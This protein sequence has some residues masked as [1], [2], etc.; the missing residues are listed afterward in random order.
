[1]DADIWYKNS[2]F[3]CHF[4]Y[5][6]SWQFKDFIKCISV[7]L[8]Q[9]QLRFSCKFDQTT[10]FQ[11][12]YKFL[13]WNNLLFHGCTFLNFGCNVCLFSMCCTTHFGF[14]LF[15]IYDFNCFQELF[16]WS[17]LF[18]LSD[19]SKKPLKNM[20][21][22]LCEKLIMLIPFIWEVKPEV[23]EFQ[24]SSILLKRINLRQ[25]HIIGKVNSYQFICIQ[26]Y[27]K[28]T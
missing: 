3:I 28:S 7:P 20:N 11:C 14:S 15:Y 1:M 24:R 10:H 5:F 4:R 22:V 9:I 16:K 18:L 12:P 19:V 21:S 8:S 27:D 26:W 23:F 6:L 17:I 2:I 25:K 13:L